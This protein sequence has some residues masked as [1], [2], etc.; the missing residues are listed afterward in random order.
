MKKIIL[1]SL[2]VILLQSA[3][4]AQSNDIDKKWRFGLRVTPQ[5]MWLLSADKNNVPAG[6]SLGAGFG[7]NLEYR[8]SN[9]A[10]LLF[11]V[12]GDFEGGKYNFKYDPD[13]KYVVQYVRDAD[14]F[15]SPESTAD[16]R[17][18]YVLKSRSVKTTHV[19]LP[20]ILKLS[21]AEYNGFKYF[22]MFGAELGIRVKSTATDQYLSV[23]KFDPIT[24]A[25]ILAAQNTEEK[26]IDISSETS[27]LPMRVGLNAGIGAEYRL[28]GTTSVFFSV[29]FFR[30]FTNLMKKTADY[31]F[32]RTDNSG[33]S[34]TT[35]SYVKQNLKQSAVRVNIGIMF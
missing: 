14:E 25:P 32:F 12:G 23:Y 10:A 26:D 17:M 8:F 18:L 9:V 11:G 3:L 30:S 6:T 33:G 27:L 35:Y 19:T 4:V 29:N 28:G 15:V 24:K 5:P 22:G 7:L 20:L 21:T 31:T 1:S 13:N 2:A 16:T 34:G